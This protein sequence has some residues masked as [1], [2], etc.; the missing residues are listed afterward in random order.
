MMTGE[1]VTEGARRATGVTPSPGERKG[2]YHECRANNKTKEAVSNP[3]ERI[4][5][6]PGNT[7]PPVSGR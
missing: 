4:P 5:D 6:I 1:G 3:R 7:V 2:G